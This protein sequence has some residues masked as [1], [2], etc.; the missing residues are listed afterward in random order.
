MQVANSLSLVLF[1][2]GD[3]HGKLEFMQFH[4]APLKSLCC[5]RRSAEFC[6]YMLSVILV[7]SENAADGYFDKQ[8]SLK[9]FTD[10]S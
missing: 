3:T 6:Y 9:H 2:K 7:A 8:C 5:N 10:I 4:T 1:F